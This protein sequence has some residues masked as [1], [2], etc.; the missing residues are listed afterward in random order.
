MAQAMAFIDATVVLLFVLCF[1]KLCDDW[2]DNNP[3]RFGFRIIFVA[4]I[5]RAFDNNLL[6]ACQLQLNF[7]RSQR[8]QR[9][10][11]TQNFH[12]ST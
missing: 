12:A 8:S 2:P 7:K 5:M 6:S 3:A 4:S 11:Q 9:T 1:D 10:T